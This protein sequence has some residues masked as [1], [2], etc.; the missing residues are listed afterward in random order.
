LQVFKHCEAVIA[1]L[2]ENDPNWERTFALKHNL[3]AFLATYRKRYKMKKKTGY[4]TDCT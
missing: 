2:D 1:T 4:E 3:N